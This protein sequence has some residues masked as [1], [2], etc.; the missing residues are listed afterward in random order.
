MVVVVL[1]IIFAFLIPIISAMA[2][3]NM[4]NKKPYTAHVIV[5]S[6]FFAVI[7]ATLLLVK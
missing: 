4:I 6:I 5:V 2:I 7:I 3:D 1:S